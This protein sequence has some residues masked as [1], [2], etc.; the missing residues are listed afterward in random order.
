MGFCIVLGFRLERW[1]G[2]I[3]VFVDTFRFAS[4]WICIGYFS[5]CLGDMKSVFRVWG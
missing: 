4:R 1:E 5:G 2:E 3:E